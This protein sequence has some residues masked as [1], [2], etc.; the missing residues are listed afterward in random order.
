MYYN[1]KS[2]GKGPIDDVGGTVKNVIFWKEKS[3]FLTIHTPS[4]FHQVVLKYVNLPAIKSIYLAE[5]DVLEEPKNMDQ[6][7]KPFVETL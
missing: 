5:N 6:E 7:V 3:S 2:H 4:E 1:E